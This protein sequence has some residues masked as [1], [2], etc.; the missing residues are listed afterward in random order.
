MISPDWKQAVAISAF[1]VLGHLEQIQSHSLWA[2][3]GACASLI[4]FK[5]RI[6]NETGNKGYFALNIP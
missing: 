5:V 3:S 4:I 1:P 2:L 6:L